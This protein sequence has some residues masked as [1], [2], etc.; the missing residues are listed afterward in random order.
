MVVAGPPTS[1]GELGLRKTVLLPRQRHE[2]PTQN[3]IWLCDY[4][5][6]LPLGSDTTC[7]AQACVEDE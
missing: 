5:N 3:P 1:T 7:L 2:F 6:L 4:T